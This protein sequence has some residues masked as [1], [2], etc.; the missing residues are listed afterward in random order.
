MGVVLWEVL[1]TQRLF[2][3]E[4][5]VATLKKLL[6][7]PIPPPSSVRP[8][9]AP[10]DPVL[11]KAL[12]RP[13]DE[14]FQTGGE[15]MEAIEKAAAAAVGGMG[16]TRDVSALVREF[17]AP[18]LEKEQAAIRSAIERLDGDAP[19][20]YST[21]RHDA[22][23]DQ[24]PSQPPTVSGKIDGLP[25]PVEVEKK[26]PMGLVVGLILALGVVAGLVAAFWPSDQPSPDDTD[27]DVVAQPEPEPAPEPE[28]E[29][30]P[31]T[32]EGDTTMATAEGET[33]VT[34]ESSAAQMTTASNDEET[35]TQDQ[36][37][38][39]VMRRGRRGMRG[40]GRMQQNDDDED[41]VL[42]NPYRSN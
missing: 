31:A 25:P 38:R 2:K 13:L 23:E 12:A 26:R 19:K 4:T 9:L 16:T 20:A 11:A 34:M 36:V 17:A 1:T 29:P 39:P 40:G 37:R 32:T 6:E 8:E 35:E 15:M 28:P 42:S 18:K 22:L 27:V 7:D 30:E 41:E 24:V 14:R 21:G 10:F 33:E 3:A 5:N